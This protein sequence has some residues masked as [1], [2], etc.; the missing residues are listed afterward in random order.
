MSFGAIL[1]AAERL[2]LEDQEELADLLGKHI[3]EG[4]RSEIAADVRNSLRDFRAGKCLPKTAA[5]LAAEILE[6]AMRCSDPKHSSVQRG[7]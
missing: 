2:S 7:E 5:E 3:R 4:K 1:D 6:R